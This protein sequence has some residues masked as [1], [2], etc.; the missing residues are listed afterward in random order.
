MVTDAAG[1]DVRLRE[2]T[3]GTP[4]PPDRPRAGFRLARDPARAKPR[5]AGGPLTAEPAT[6]R[7][8]A[9]VER[10]PVGT[11]TDVPP[12]GRSV[13]GSVG[14]QRTLLGVH[15][16]RSWYASYPRS[17]SLGRGGLNRSPAR[18]AGACWGRAASGASVSR[19]RRPATVLLVGGAAPR[20]L[21][22]K[23]PTPTVGRDVTHA[24][25]RAPAASRPA[26]PAR[27]LRAAAG[28][29]GHAGSGASRHVVA[30]R[31]RGTCAPDRDGPP[32]RR[33]AAASSGSPFPAPVAPTRRTDT[34]TH[35]G[36]AGERCSARSGSPPSAG[37]RRGCR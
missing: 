5:P 33:P 14:S 28:D 37:P 21:A 35:P 11:S 6:S 29:D 32:S 23:R 8:T 12:V 1:R 15:R 16:G 24:F 20:R 3:R 19:T 17:R 22:H 31:Q 9:D 27:P 26:T 34:P 13:P 7:W 25:G 36:R 2:G 18:R 30:S 4:G 10:S